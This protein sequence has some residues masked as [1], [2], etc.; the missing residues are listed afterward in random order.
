MGRDTIQA[1]AC[2]DKHTIS[3]IIPHI[4]ISPFLFPHF[5]GPSKEIRQT[6]HARLWE[7]KGYCR[8]V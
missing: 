5:R 1:E 2:R 6:L 4:F 8:V 7:H 3:I